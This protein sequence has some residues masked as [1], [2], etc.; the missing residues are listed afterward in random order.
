MA[1]RELTDAEVFGGVPGKVWNE[2]QRQGIDP[3]LAL[4]VARQESAFRTDAV[5]PKGARGVMQLMDGTAR[6]LG[7][8]PNDVDQNIEGGVRY[9]KKQL[10]DFGS[11]DLAL[12]AYNAGPGAVRKYGGVPPYAETQDYVSRI[13]G[14]GQSGS[15][16]ELS[17]E[18]VFGSAGATPREAAVTVEVPGK[19]ELGV[20]RAYAPPRKPQALPQRQ[21]P[22]IAQDAVSG[23]VQPFKDL[24][25]T[26]SARM[27]APRQAPASVGDFLKGAFVDP[28]VDSASLLGGVANIASAPIQAAVRP[29]ARGVNRIA[30]PMYEKGPSILSPEFWD[31]KADIP[32]RLDEPGRQAAIE[33]SINT[34]LSGARAA[35][36]RA[37]AG[38]TPQPRN[39]ADLKKMR[40]AAYNEVRDMGVAYSPKAGATLA[41][42]IGYELAT[43]RINPKVTP[44]AHAVMEDLQDQLRAGRPLTLDTLDDMRK[45]VQRA[46][47]R[48]DDAEQFFGGRI[49]ELID[50]FIDN[51]GPDAVINGDGPAAREAL[52]RARALNS[53]YRKLE[54]VENAMD[55]ADLRAASTYAGGNKANA[56]RQNIRPL[57]DPTS[58]KRIRNLTPAETKAANKVVRGTGGANA[59]RQVGKVLDPRGLLGQI[60]L[61]PLGIPTVGIAPTVGA[62]ASEASNLYTA[63]ALKEL[64]NLIARGGGAA[65]KVPPKL[66][67]LQ[68]AGRAP[69]RLLSPAGIVGAGTVAAPAARI[70]S[71]KAGPSKARTALPK[72]RQTQAGR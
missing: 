13:N 15:A 16:R 14:G 60:A 28:V 20:G 40:T 65:S 51:A 66:P 9:L 64:S 56:A 23:F 35:A 62:L 3:T 12:A 58:S 48:G 11:P 46:T 21:G 29:I 4:R 42:N 43:D 38:A 5:S 26:V 70:P 72:K 44:K 68:L 59:A 71:K 31:N 39:A 25:A 33:G 2:A 63:K 67:T 55:S 22:T 45:Q 24:G 34:A 17:D 32:R 6:D 69:V 61:G 50:D 1:P 41:D 49:R 30:P 47:G 36:P 54:A 53:Q 52:L 10:D 8:D 27:N 19:P 57:I 18:E 7:V 37:A